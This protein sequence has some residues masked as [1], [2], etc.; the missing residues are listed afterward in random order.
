MKPVYTTYI[1]D[2]EVKLLCRASGQPTP[3]ITWSRYSGLDSQ[4]NKNVR[5]KDGSWISYGET[6][7]IRNVEETDA[8]L[9][10]CAAK[11]NVDPEDVS[12]AQYD[13]QLQ[14]H[15]RPSSSSMQHEVG[16]APNKNYYSY[17]DC[18]IVGYPTPEMYFWKV[19]PTQ[20]LTDQ[21][22]KSSTGAIDAIYKM[23]GLTEDECWAMWEKDEGPLK[24]TSERFLSHHQ[25]QEKVG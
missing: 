23:K 20:N 16:Q 5:F 19:K 6:L 10:R 1:G 9:Y 13:I 17:I 2:P 12:M 22:G 21:Y 4:G 7:T 14:V 25:L 18:E 3:N 15:Y 11:N 8:G 24:Q